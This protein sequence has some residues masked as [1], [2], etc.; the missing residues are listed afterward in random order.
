MP[1]CINKSHPSYQQLLSGTSVNPQILD[2]KI[3]AWQTQNNTSEFPT[4]QDIGVSPSATLASS[5]VKPGVDF[6]FEQNPELATIGSKEQYSQ[7]LSTIFKDSKVKDIVYHGGT[8]ESSFSKDYIGKSTIHTNKNDFNQPK[9]FYFTTSKNSALTYGSV[10]NV[11][12][13]IKSPAILEQEF[14]DNGFGLKRK[15]KFT[16]VQ[17]LDLKNKDSFILKDIFDAKYL[18]TLSDRDLLNDVNGLKQLKLNEEREVQHGDTIGVFDPNQIH[19]L[20][21]QADIQ[22]FKDFVQGKQFQKLTAE[23]KAKTIEQVTKEHRSINNQSE[24]SN[25]VMLQVSP[26]AAEIIRR[27]VKGFKLVP[28]FGFAY[29]FRTRDGK[30][31]DK[32]VD[33]IN[34]WLNKNGYGDIVQFARETTYNTINPVFPKRTNFSI[35]TMP[36]VPQAQLKRIREYLG[37]IGVDATKLAQIEIDGSKLTINGLADPLSML[38]QYVEGLEDSVLPEEAFH[39]AVELMEVQHPQ[40]LSRLL[41][42]VP[43][44]PGYGSIFDTYAGRYQKDG[45]PDVRKIRKEAVAKYLAMAIS[46]KP[47][48]GITVPSGILQ[49]IAEWWRALVESLKNLFG[50][51]STDLFKQTAEQILQEENIGT[52]RDTLLTNV[53]YL[54]QYMPSG[55]ATQIAEWAESDISNS[56]LSNKIN[57][58]LNDN[59]KLSFAQVE[60]TRAQSNPVQDS[61]WKK[62][63]DVER[64]ITK[65]VDID[66]DINEYRI[67]DRKIKNR[68]TDVAKKAYSMF[69]QQAPNKRSEFLRT[70]GTRIHSQIEDIIKRYTDNDGFI[71]T[72][73]FGELSGTPQMIASTDAVDQEIYN[74]LE[75]YVKELLEDYLERS[76]DVRIRTE[77]VVYN[78]KNDIAGTIDFLAIHP[79]GS[80]DI[81]DWKSMNIDVTRNDDIPWFKIQP[82]RIQLGEYRK[83]LQANYGV[84]NFD[85]I[86]IVP[87]NVTLKIE[88]GQEPRII[89]FQVGT[90]DPKKES[91]DYLL[92]LP[93]E[94]ESTGIKAV[95]DLLVQL[96][97]LYKRLQQNKPNPEERFKWIEQ[98]SVLYKAIRKL[99]IQHDIKPTL[100]YARI[101]TKE[102][103]ATLQL[104]ADLLNSNQSDISDEAI[105]GF[106]RNLLNLRNKLFPFEHIGSREIRNLVSEEERKE[107]SIIQTELN[108]YS[109]DIDDLLLKF[110][111]KFLG[112]RLGIIGLTLAE[113]DYNNLAALF[114]KTNKGGTTALNTF[115]RLKESVT[116]WAEIEKRKRLNEELKVKAAYDTWARS[117]GLSARN[118]FDILYRVDEKGNKLNLRLQTIQ[119]EFYKEFDKARE[120]RNNQWF[121]DNINLDEFRE[122][123]EEDKKRRIQQIQDTSYS[124]DPEQNKTIQDQRI[125]AV[126]ESFNLEP[127]GKGWGNYNMKR[128]ANEKWYTSEYKELLKP[129]NKPALDLYNWTQGIVDEAVN[130]GIVNPSHRRAFLPF[131]K[132]SGLAEKMIF[133]GNPKIGQGLWD[134]ITTHEYD[135]GFGKRDPLTKELIREIPMYYAHDFTGNMDMDYISTD[136]FEVMRLFNEKLIDYKA[137]TSIKDRVEALETIEMLK[138]SLLTDQKGNIIRDPSTDLLV[139]KQGN[140]VNYNILKEHVDAILYDQQYK[141]GSM[142]QSF[143][144]ISPKIDRIGESI[145]KTIGLD[146][147]PTNL[148]GRGVSAAK[149]L[150]SINRFFTNKVMGLN[151]AIPISNL[152]G[153]K[154]QSYI[155]AGKYYTKEDLLKAEWQ[156]ASQYFT[157]G[158][159][160]VLLKIIRDLNPF[161][162][163]NN[164]RSKKTTVSQI[165]DFDFV[166][167][168]L[169]SLNTAEGKL[170]QFAHIVAMINNAILIDGQVVNVNQYLRNKY[171]GQRWS[172]DRQNVLQQMEKEKK[173]LLDQ[174]G[175]KKVAKIN[176][177]GELE[178]INLLDPTFAKYRS[179]IVNLTMEFTGASTPD[180][181]ARAER[182]LFLK[183]AL[184]FK[185]WIVPIATPRFAA[186][187]YTPGTDTYEWGRVRTLLR[188]VLRSGIKSV[189]RLINV[190]S[191][192]QAGIEYMKELLEYKREE[193]ERRTG[194][195]LGIDSDDF[196]DMVRQNI[197]NDFKDLIFLVS[198]SAMI[199]A[200]ASLEPDEDDK[201]AQGYYKFSYRMLD[202]VWDELLFYYNPIAF[203]Q[204][205]SGSVFPGLGLL[206]DVAKLF[207]NIGKELLGDDESQEEAHP[208]KYLLRMF[209]LTNT[210]SYY[211]AVA[212]PEFAK[213][214]GI[215]IST[216]SRR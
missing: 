83:I 140:E 112:E 175:L 133:G 134:A 9:A 80:V 14:E 42:A 182:N 78:P 11:I 178:G 45:K 145:N 76:P 169:M 166:N 1:H 172:A 141:D 215:R 7:Y 137:L 90:A 109:K 146:I 144:T 202:R 194:K 47:Y 30:I 88:T 208:V 161:V 167:D 150:T 63:E 197:R 149:L 151:I 119:S 153:G 200:L 79:D 127:G 102:L 96:N 209:P 37:R 180:N 35:G 46:G 162:T 69:E 204:I 116:N 18:K 193:Y 71:R 55:K 128:F 74:R 130:L 8:V 198:L 160:R 135:Q 48:R 213:E 114:F 191:G 97:A 19:I 82:F 183:S 174:Y 121:I 23:E 163:H 170:T 132:K 56:E 20:G 184:V 103:D 38:V 26:D 40:L 2:A 32:Q 139:T 72:D 44:M 50:K 122:W 108:D 34:R 101:L 138:D 185:N 73:E 207:Y 21:S 52:V 87:M 164:L 210:L 171:S 29:S 187:R 99:H 173:E 94:D 105:S 188:I 179:L 95:D 92:P 77:S 59:E 57:E 177:K 113:K 214:N 201:E 126:E 115:V 5:L 106:L 70:A 143:M 43:E 93:T 65:V 60:E 68:V 12:L 25:P 4:L 58:Y 104:G 107:I 100:D 124:P 216:E 155:N 3:I 31:S 66:N 22:G 33:R 158:E 186:L 27:V 199:L 142:T 81:L 195:T 39:I 190:A 192:N 86:R 181:I 89:G 84:K 54:S 129:E 125:A 206:S 147:F 85:R 159:E 110:G 157:N 120:S 205:V 64:T 28:V 36:R 91:M 117:K 41:S 67:G 154:A 212:S 165:S 203:E 15:N 53:D 62:I 211:M 17:D 111:D 156:V 148:G 6:V 189:N 49:K 118:Y 168:L 13:N 131:V 136:L 51:A 16:S 152:L 123:A 24:Y 176:D 10:K 75:V 196:M 61:V 98:L